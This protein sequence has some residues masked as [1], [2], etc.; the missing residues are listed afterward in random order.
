[1][2]LWLPTARFTPELAL[3]DLAGVGLV[4]GWVMS[5]DG[6]EASVL[7]AVGMGGPGASYNALAALA[8]EA[9]L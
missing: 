1:V 4:H 3:F 2:V 6:P 7:S 5:P 9:G 8:V